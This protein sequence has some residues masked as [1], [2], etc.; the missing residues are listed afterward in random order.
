ML[1]P[2]VGAQ[3]K[4]GP[5]RLMKRRMRGG[6]PRIAVPTAVGPLPIDE[7]VGKLVKAAIVAQAGAASRVKSQ[8]LLGGMSPVATIDWWSVPNAE[9]PIEH[10]VREFGHTRV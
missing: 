3:A 1:V 10:R 2:A 5:E 8:A 6:W 7:Q 9:G 4:Q